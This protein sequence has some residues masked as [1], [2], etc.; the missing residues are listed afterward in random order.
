M[1][2]RSTP[3]G[4]ELTR[5]RIATGGGMARF[6]GTV[7]GSEAARGLPPPPAPAAAGEGGR[8]GGRGGRGGAAGAPAAPAAAPAAPGGPP[9][10]AP[11]APGGAAAAPAPGAAGAP[12]AGRGA[13]P[14]AAPAGRGG[15]SPA[16]RPS[17]PERQVAQAGDWN[18]L[19]IV[20]DATLL[21][22]RI[23]NGRQGG[24]AVSE[25]MGM[26]GPIALYV[27]GTGEVR[28]RDVG[29]QGRQPEALR[30]GRALR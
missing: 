3:S 17:S 20:I 22:P 26:F 11:A 2:S 8:A 24:S 23:N 21:R 19:D 18:A 5:D 14:A 16:V 29:L 1:R 28:F 9:A 12:A 15:L 10:A 6:A 30:E 25:E 27:G 7:T 4:K 13:A